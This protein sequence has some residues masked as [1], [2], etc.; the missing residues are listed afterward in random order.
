MID[1][2]ASVRR[3]NHE[4]HHNEEEAIRTKAWLLIRVGSQLVLALV[5]LASAAPATSVVA[6]TRGVHGPTYFRLVSDAGIAFS[7]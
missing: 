5:G 2:T 1:C 7:Q 6:T 3:R 4:Q